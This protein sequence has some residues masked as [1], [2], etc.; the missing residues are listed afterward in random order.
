MKKSER[1]DIHTISM[2]VANKPGVLV[3]I[4]L[5]FARRGYNIDSLVVSPTV[6]P[7]F[8]RL[9][10][11]A[12]GNPE[13]LEQIV[14]QT[15]KLVD[16]IHAT[17]HTPADAIEK[18]MALLKIRLKSSSKAALEK[19]LKRF[20]AHLVNLSDNAA[21]IEQTGSTAELDQLEEELK[22]FGIIEMVRTGKLVMARGK[23]ST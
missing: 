22:K 7:K 6:D 2:L 18:E 20:H 10:I 5:V 23:E 21:I 15:T 3:R 9:T 4:A 17:E 1:K 13:T 12:Q 11:A 19:L 8:S 16:V 14:K